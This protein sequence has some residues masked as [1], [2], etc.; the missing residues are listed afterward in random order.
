MV[1]FDELGDYDLSLYEED[2]GSLVSEYRDVE[3][4]EE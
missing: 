3:C 4:E 2:E 1:V